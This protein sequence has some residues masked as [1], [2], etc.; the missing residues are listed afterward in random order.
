MARWRLITSIL[1]I[2]AVLLWATLFLLNLRPE[3]G[4]AVP[5]G[6]FP[7]QETLRLQT[8]LSRLPGWVAP[9]ELLITLFLAGIANLYLF[10]ARLHNMLRTLSLGWARL[11]SLTL[12]GIGFALLLVFFAI[13]AA[14]AR[15]TFPF[16]ILAAIALVFLSVWGF[17]GVAYALGRFLLLRAGWARRSPAAALALGLIL[18]VPLVRIPFAGALIMLIYIGL[19]LGLVVV[20]RF[21][22]NESWSLIPLLEEDIQ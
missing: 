21:G 18:L 19:G 12:V 9:V 3:V 16:T 4:R 20:T 10:P 13:G 17:L 6:L 14:L 7:S 11:L 2:L 22:S 1:I 5:H 8:P 15:I